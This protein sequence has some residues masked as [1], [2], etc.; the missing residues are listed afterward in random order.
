MTIKGMI[1]AELF[2]VDETTGAGFAGA[3]VAAGGLLA[4]TT[5]LRHSV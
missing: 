4:A 2:V 5:G 3:G 1:G